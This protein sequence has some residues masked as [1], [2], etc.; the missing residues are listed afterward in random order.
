MQDIPWLEIVVAVGG[1]SG[2]AALINSFTKA[3]ASRVDSLCQ[4]I[5]SQNEHILRVEAELREW[6]RKYYALAVIVR[7]LG[8]YQDEEGEWHREQD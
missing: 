8:Y 4:I 3:S 7:R 1:L 5:D 6:K 2:I